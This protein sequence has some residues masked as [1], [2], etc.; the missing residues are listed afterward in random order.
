MRV[1]SVTR[2]V[3]LGLEMG[4]AAAEREG[5]PCALQLS[6]RGWHGP[7][8]GE[9]PACAGV[10]LELGENGGAEGVGWSTTF[11]MRSGSAATGWCSMGA[12]WWCEQ[13]ERIWRAAW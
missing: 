12:R 8:G 1:E 7:E 11:R 2:R 13:R 6:E 9:L 3:A 5:S 10:E 4:R